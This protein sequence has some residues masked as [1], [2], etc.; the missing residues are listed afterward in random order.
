[1]HQQPKILIVD[2]SAIVRKALTR[3]LEQFGARV[4]QAEDGQQGVDAA[5]AGGF[6]LVISDVEM[7][8]LNGFGL[9]EKLKNAPETRGVPVIM[10]SSLDADKDVDQGFKAGAAAYVSK[11]EAKTQLIETIERVL[12]KSRFQR[13]RL[14]LVV[15]DSQTVRNLV[16]KALAEAGF[17]VAAAENGKSALR[18]IAFQR[19]DLII[20]DIDMPEMNG[21]ELC[22]ALRANPAL[23]GIPCVIMSANSDR[24]TI[25]RLLYLGAA[26][27]L[28]KPF[29]LEQIVIAVE[30]LLS[31]HFLILLKEKERLDTERR[32]M[33]AGITSLI[34]ALE[35]RDSYTRGH[36]ETVA[37]LVEAMGRTMNIDAEEIEILGIAGRL[38]DI[39]KIGVPDSILLKPGRLSDEE[40][41][42][43]RQHP[44][45]GA[46]I[47]SAIPS[48]NPLLP[49]ILHHHER[50]D[51][52][53]YPEGQ[54]GQE[55][56]L[57]ARMTAV[58]DTYHA[59]TS[60]RPYRRGMS[61]DQAMGIIEEA[62]GTQLCPE[63]VDAFK[64]SEPQLTQAAA[65]R[66]APGNS[67]K[68]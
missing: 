58:A 63:C 1:M 30:R 32:M 39:G 23:A 8:C 31:D 41:L 67:P 60:D 65:A 2:D 50:F 4:T 53:G 51:G 14:V 55:V 35:A 24:S 27:Y 49:V 48:I 46:S 12:A 66:S 36:S 44:T 15:D 10:L 45:I 47:L 21:I 17:Q 64:M 61:H 20:S 56:M 5:L 62:R 59:L 57:W 33:L 6:D 9:C 37:A 25:R 42:I 26:G 22:K 18:S 16:T 38:H 3:Q 52:Q 54:K 19:P 34:A 29:N 11:S 40:M 68:T 43:I 7:P 28:I 13:N